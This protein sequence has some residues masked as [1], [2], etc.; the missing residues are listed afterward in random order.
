[1]YCITHMVL[2]SAIV[3]EAKQ[4]Q[5]YVITVGGGGQQHGLYT[6]TDIQTH[7]YSSA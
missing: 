7:A 2:D 5:V 1:M 6:C 4:A 3:A